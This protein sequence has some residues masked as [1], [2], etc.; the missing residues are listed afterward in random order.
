MNDKMLGMVSIHIY[1]PY[2]LIV[3]LQKS[4]FTVFVN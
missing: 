3:I 2:L 4:T 1:G